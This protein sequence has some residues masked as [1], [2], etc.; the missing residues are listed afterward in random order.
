MSNIYHTEPPTQGKVLLHT[1]FG[2]IDIELWPKEAPLA[3]RNFVQLALEGYYDH[4]P[5]HRVI[6]DFMLQMGDPTGSGE[7]GESVWNK[8]FKDEIHGRIK[9][10]HR[11]QVACANQNKPHSNGSQFFITLGACE[12]LDRKHTIFGKVTGNTF[13]NVV[14]GSEVEVDALDKP[15]DLLEITSVEVLWNPFDDIVPRDLSKLKKK[16]LSISSTTAT[17]VGG[18]DTKKKSIVK[19]TKNTKLLSFGDEEES[20]MLVA[21]GIHSSHDSKLKDSKLSSEVAVELQA[22]RQQQEEKSRPVDDESN[23]KKKKL[24]SGAGE[25]QRPSGD[26]TDP[27]TTSNSSALADSAEDFEERMRKKISERHRAHKVSSRGEREGGVGDRRDKV[28]AVPEDDSAD[29]ETSDMEA[30]VR[31][32]GDSLGV[33]RK[34]K[35]E[36]EFDTVKKELL[37]ARKAVT[38]LTGAEATKARETAASESLVSTHQQYRQRFLKRKKEF[39]E[40]QEETLEKL[41]MFSEKI[42]SSKATAVAAPEVKVEVESYHGQVLEHDSDD[43]NGTE[44]LEDWYVGKL[45]FRKKHIDDA[46]RGGDGRKMDDYAVIDNRNKN[47]DKDDRKPR[48]GSSSR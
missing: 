36:A 32:A 44:V 35:M 13:Y 10:N 7:G 21:G 9:F 46:Y 29:M 1:S 16:V 17:S 27:S 38:V 18:K 3:C 39:G 2:D 28:F 34:Q 40:R 12:W 4:T 19:A 15:I 33:A 45:K 31:G 42:Q 24:A 47:S 23:N 8:P 6:K 43:E 48:P 11:G 41:K 22:L 5:V 20:P 37:R 26:Q 14:R 30:L 25:I